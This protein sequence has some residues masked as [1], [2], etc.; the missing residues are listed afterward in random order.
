MKKVL[1]WIKNKSIY[2]ITYDENGLSNDLSKQ[3][4]EQILNDLSKEG[5]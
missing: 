3:E 1:K 2:G 4:K 5:Y